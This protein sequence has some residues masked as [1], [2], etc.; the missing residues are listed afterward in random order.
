MADGRDE[1]GFMRSIAGSGDNRP[2]RKK[3][4]DVGGVA[5][6]LEIPDVIQILFSPF[7]VTRVRSK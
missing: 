4:D 6:L 2:A 1:F 3:T 7:R 5:R